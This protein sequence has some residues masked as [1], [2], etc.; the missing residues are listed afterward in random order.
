MSP[1]NSHK[2]YE[3]VISPLLQL[4]PSSC[5]VLQQTGEA[6]FSLRSIKSEN[7]KGVDG[8]YQL[9]FMRHISKDIKNTLHICLNRKEI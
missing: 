6:F 2:V 3:E 4:C 7:A 9:S 8:R 1:I 5:K